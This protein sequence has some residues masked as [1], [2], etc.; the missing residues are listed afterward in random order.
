MGV[1][2]N[3]TE[4]KEREL[5]FKNLTDNAVDV[6]YTTDLF[7]TCNYVNQAAEQVLGYSKEELTG[8]SFSIVVSPKDFELVGAHYI[9]QFQEKIETSFLEFRALKKDGEEIWVGQTVKTLFDEVNK[10]HIK[11]FQ[12]IVRDISLR[13]EFEE[14][15]TKSES[16]FQQIARAI[17]DVF[18]LYS[19]VEKKYLYIS[20]NSNVILGI[21][22]ELFFNSK[23]NYNENHIHKEDIE[24]ANDAIKKISKGKKYDIQYRI[25]KNGKIH[26]MNEKGFPILDDAGNVSTFSGV[27][28]DVTKIRRSSERIVRQNLKI[29]QSIHYAK[30]IQDSTLPSQANFNRIL[31][32]SFIFFSPK[33][34]VSGD[35]Y[36]VDTFLFEENRE[37]KLALLGDC[38]GHGVPGS[39]LSL[40]C[41]ALLK[42][43]MTKQ[44]IITPNLILDIVRNKIIQLFQSN[45]EK[46]IH[47]GMDL[48]LVVLDQSENKVYFSGAN[49]DCNVVRKKKL[50]VYRGDRQHVGYN[51]YSQPFTMSNID[52]QKGDK[53][54]IYSDGFADQFGAATNKKFKRRN[55][56][57]LI[58]EISNA[59]MQDQYEIFK[60]TFF[61]WKGENTHT[62]DVTIIGISV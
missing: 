19:I 61:E 17:N 56:N 35:F 1:S 7:G 57:N 59:P 30:K 41:I 55:L 22:S 13:K 45:S 25:I 47:D 54:Y 36:L 16:N 52:I 18:F 38:T 49:L 14:K 60:D 29:G 53:I 40:L 24:I 51:E 33:D 27:C 12:G 43:S 46:H 3:I 32:D 31:K 9:N 50:Q 5:V 34:V 48:A 11:G 28:R 15:L 42:E 39:I 20:P 44:L 10:K 37:V 62:D 26:W 58:I 23:F 6:I 8:A 2:R 4:Q 21:E